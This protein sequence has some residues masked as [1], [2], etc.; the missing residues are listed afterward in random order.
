MKMIKFLINYFANKL[1]TPTFVACFLRDHEE[2]PCMHYDS[3]TEPQQSMLIAKFVRP[4]RKKVK[5][6]N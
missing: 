1:F 5:G 2:F 4:D 3:P 6:K